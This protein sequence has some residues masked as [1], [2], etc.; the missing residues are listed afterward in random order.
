MLS[1]STEKMEIPDV[2]PH[3]YSQWIFEKSDKNV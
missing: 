2:N 1:V 3:A